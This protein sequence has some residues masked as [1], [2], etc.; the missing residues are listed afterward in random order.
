VLLA[1]VQERPRF[2]R[3]AQPA[4]HKHLGKWPAHPQLTP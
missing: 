1:G 3:L 2:E 4:A